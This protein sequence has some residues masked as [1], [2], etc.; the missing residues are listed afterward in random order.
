VADELDRVRLGPAT[1]KDREFVRV[2]S[3]R[4]FSRFGDY[5]RTLPCW[6]GLPD[7]ETLIARVNGEPIGFTM[8]GPKPLEPG[9]TELLAIAVV[10]DW[11]SRG[12]G[13]LLLAGSEER[14]RASARGRGRPILVATVAE[15]NDAA[16]GLFRRHGFVE[17]HDDDGRYPG[18]QRSF[19]V[20]K[21]I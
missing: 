19:N 18:G 6:M 4:V 13:A 2:L 1:E 5:D 12:V 8:L 3:A 7:V 16:R 9:V 10:P 17:L 20:R 21:C 11:Q 14:A 15:D